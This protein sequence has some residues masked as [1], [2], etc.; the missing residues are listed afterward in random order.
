MEGLQTPFNKT[1]LEIMRLLN[2]ISSEEELRELKT[3]IGQY[4]ANKIIKETDRI[5][6]ER[7][8]TQQTMDAWIN[9]PT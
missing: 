6:D 2:D 7:G 5:W 4:Y 8:Y 3:F 9:E 1:Q